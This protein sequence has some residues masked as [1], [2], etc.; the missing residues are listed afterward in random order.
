MAIDV[1][2]GLQAHRHAINGQDGR[3]TQPGQFDMRRGSGQPAVREGP[4]HLR[5]IA[6]SGFD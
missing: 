1:E 2:T 4:G 6:G 3:L 5:G